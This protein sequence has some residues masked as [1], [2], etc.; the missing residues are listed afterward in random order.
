MI[1][2]RIANLPQPRR[3]GDA[4]FGQLSKELLNL[5]KHTSYSQIP[6]YTQKYVLSYFLL[7]D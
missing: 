3:T 4:T 7:S 5:I 1:A 6:E 2:A